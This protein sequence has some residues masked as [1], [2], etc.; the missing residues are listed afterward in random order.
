MFARKTRWPD[1]QIAMDSIGLVTSHPYLLSRHLRRMD[2]SIHKLASGYRIVLRHWL[3]PTNRPSL[4]ERIKS[5]ILDKLI[6]RILKTYLFVVIADSD[7]CGLDLLK[8]TNYIET[9]SFPWDLKI[10]G[11]YAGIISM[12]Y[13]GFISLFL[14]LPKWPEWTRSSQF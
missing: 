5:K 6:I 10:H 7:V 13:Y 2:P 12:T 9:M 4:D 8:R 11:N 14:L 3:F 1:F